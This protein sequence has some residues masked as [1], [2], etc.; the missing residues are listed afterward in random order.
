MPEDDL[1]INLEYNRLL[2]EDLEKQLQERPYQEL[3]R[4]FP[5]E[6]SIER[7]YMLS[8]SRWVRTPELT[9]EDPLG[10]NPP[11]DSKL[12]GLRWWYDQGFGG[13][14]DARIWATVCSRH[15]PIDPFVQKMESWISDLPSIT[16]DYE[17]VG[18]RSVYTVSE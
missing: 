3:V 14:G 17:S 16:D 6:F 18:A 15:G 11:F 13:E 10:P 9:E 2:R 4:V 5:T 8:G 12:D 1:I 7:R